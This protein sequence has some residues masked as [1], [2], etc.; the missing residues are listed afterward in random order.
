MENWEKEENMREAERKTNNLLK[1]LG[2]N[3]KDL[4]VET[5]L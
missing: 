3:V 5:E 4:D 1:Y 2:I